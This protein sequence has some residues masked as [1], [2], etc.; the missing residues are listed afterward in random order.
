M[1][2]ISEEY[3]RI[4]QIK[5]AKIPVAEESVLY[6][7]FSARRKLAEK[8]D[9]D[10]LTEEDRKTLLFAFTDIENKIKKFEL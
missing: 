7:Y 5:S 1:K 4:Q 10:M 3:F 2:A 6:S 9:R 8:L